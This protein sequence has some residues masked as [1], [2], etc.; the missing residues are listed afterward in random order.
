MQYK[1]W[2]I[3]SEWLPKKNGGIWL[4]QEPTDGRPKVPSGAPVPLVP[5]RMRNFDEVAKGLGGFVNFGIQWQT[6]ISLVS[7][8]DRMSH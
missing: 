8:E 1:L 4:G 3:D 5:Q 7:S 2:C 6:M